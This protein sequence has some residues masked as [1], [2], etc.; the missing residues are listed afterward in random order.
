VTLDEV[1]GA[2][3]EAGDEATRRTYLRHGA[4]EPLFGVRLGALR[5]L[6]KAGQTAAG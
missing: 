3:E 2:L 1:M 4:R 5:P 6:A